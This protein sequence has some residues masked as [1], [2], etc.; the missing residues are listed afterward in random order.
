MTIALQRL[1]SSRLLLLAGLLACFLSHTV[2]ADEPPPPS[3]VWQSA[4]DLA[5]TPQK[6]WVLR[7]R[8][9][10]LS[11]QSLQTLKDAAARPH[12]PVSIE[13]FDGI[14]YELDITSTVSRINDSAV[15]RGLLKNSP[16]GDFTFFINGS[17]MAG[18]IHVGDRLFK[19]EHVSNGYH[20]LLE[21]DP[22]KLPPD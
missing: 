9:I 4:P 15:I 12:P 22:A 19:V 17:V 16:H 11:P 3:T 5:P 8:A 10:A 2:R 7:D 6:P 13:L 14:R 18:T 20:R 21:L 1:N